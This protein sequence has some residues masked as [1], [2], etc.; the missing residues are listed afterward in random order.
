MVLR[1][2]THTCTYVRT[3]THRQGS[4]VSPLF[5]SLYFYSHLLFYYNFNP[6][7]LFCLYSLSPHY[8]IYVLPQLNDHSYKYSVLTLTKFKWSQKRGG[9]GGFKEKKLYTDFLSM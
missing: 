1:A 3:H 6:V 2:H 7:C 9:G 4:S 8:V 5:S